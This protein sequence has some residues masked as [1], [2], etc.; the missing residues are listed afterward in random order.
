MFKLFFLLVGFFTGLTIHAETSSDSLLTLED[1]SDFKAADQQLIQASFPELMSQESTKGAAVVATIGGDGGCSFNSSV[2][3]TPIQDAIDWTGVTYTELR[4]VEDIYDEE[5]ITLDDRDMVIKG[6]YATCADAANDVMSD[7][8]SLDTIIQ[9]S[10]DTNPVFRIQG[11]STSNNVSFYNLT[12]R[13][14]GASNWYGGALRINNADTNVSI[15]RVAMSNNTG[16]RG[17]AIAVTGISGDASVVLNRVQINGNTAE[18]GGGLYCNNPNATLTIN[19]SSGKT[20]GVYSNTATVGDGGGA[21]IENGCVFTTYQGTQDL[22]LFGDDYRGFA[23][24]NATGH[25]GGLAVLSGATA[26]LYG[27]NTCVPFNQFWLC[28]F[29]NNTEPVSMF[30]N[31]ADSDDN[32]TGDGG[33]IYASGS[34]T[35]VLAENVYLAANFSINGAALAAVTSAE[36]TINTAFENEAG[37]IS[38]W[39]LGACVDINTN[40]AETAGGGFYVANGAIVNAANLQARNNRANA[41]VVG[42]TRDSNSELNFESGLFYANGDDGNGN[43]NDTYLFRA[44]QSSRLRLY[45]STIADNAVVSRQIG[46]NDAY[47]SLANS[48]IYDPSGVDIYTESGN[49]PTRF[50]HCLVLHENQ[51]FWSLD[52]EP[53]VVADPLF[54]DANNQNYQLLD[55]S[56]AID[57]CSQEWITAA[58]PDL[59]GN[60][61]GFDITGIPDVEGPYDAGAFE[62]ISSDLIFKHGFE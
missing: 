13:N 31:T 55:G 40:L 10:T 54:V 5:D 49:S 26:N 47:V 35:Q 17:G 11:N 37:A 60:T 38:C 15:N 51:S 29:G 8:D 61:R 9:S 46:N 58:H 62:S 6:G 21:L 7:P 4:I 28:L 53:N 27:R 19:S 57:R 24:N 59:L 18:H 48:I 12:I 44:F 22:N 23:L 16:L 3:A 1:L 32:G 43:Y 45:Y 50:T 14:S 25:G 2:R 33:A 30:F 39:Q 56:P 42:Y 20:H 34:G 41:G 52:L 36:V